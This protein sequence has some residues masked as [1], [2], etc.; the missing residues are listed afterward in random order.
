MKK[1]SNKKIEKKKVCLKPFCVIGQ[2]CPGVVL[3]DPKIL[4]G[5]AFSIGCSH[6]GGS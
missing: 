2:H 6:R 4:Q 5:I 1:I 3:A